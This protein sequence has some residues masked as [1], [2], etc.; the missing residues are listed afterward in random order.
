MTSCKLNLLRFKIITD[1]HH[2]QKAANL[3]Q[4]FLRVTCAVSAGS[5]SKEIRLLLLG[6]VS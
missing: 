1:H 4:I 3:L 6:K 5:Q 2:S